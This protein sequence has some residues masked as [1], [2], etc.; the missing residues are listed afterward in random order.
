MEKNRSSQIIRRIE[1]LMN[2]KNLN[3]NILAKNSGLNSQTIRDILNTDD[4]KLSKLISISKALDVNP[5]YWFQKAEYK[6][7]SESTEIND[8]AVTYGKMITRDDHNT[9]V[10]LMQE[11]IETLQKEIDNLKGFE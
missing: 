11:K 4:I 9:I 3:A 7:D 10:N 2:K 8:P 1:S 5:V 6:H